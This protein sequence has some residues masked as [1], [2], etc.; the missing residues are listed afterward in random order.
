M[1]ASL[2]V[3][4]KHL[5]VTCVALSFVL[6]FLRGIWHLRDTAMIRRT[7][8]RVLPHLVD[9]VLLTTA[10]GLALI[11]RQYPLVDDWLTAKVAALLLYIGL[12]IFAFRFASD[13]KQ[14]VIA[15]FAAL[16]VFGYIVSVAL[17]RSALPFAGP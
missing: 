12:G 1:L 16:C 17:S 10:V 5:H 7:W 8:V 3:P 14:Q 13:K 2:Y 15:W 9:S 11:L 4:L 6:F